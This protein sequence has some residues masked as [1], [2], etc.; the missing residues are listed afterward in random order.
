MRTAERT[1]MVMTRSGIPDRV[2]IHCWLG[3]PYIR[4][5]FKPED[6]SMYRLL[7][8]WV[9]DPLGTLVKMQQRIKK[10]STNVPD[11]GAAHYL[12]HFDEIWGLQSYLLSEAD[13]ANI[14]ITL[15]ESRDKTFSEI[16]RYTIA[17]LG[18]DFDATPEQVFGMP[19]DKKS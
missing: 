18:K 8:L 19:V 5:H 12:K 6:I 1:R 15:N 7:E 11:R 4:E 17:R 14:H 10:R 3:L 16:M 2:P 13:R 9:D